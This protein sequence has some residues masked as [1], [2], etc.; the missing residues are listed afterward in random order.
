MLTYGQLA[1]SVHRVA[2][3]L[4]RRGFRKG[5]VFATVC[6][7]ILEFPIVFYAVAALGGTMTMANPLL[8]AEELAR[9]LADAG[10]RFVLTVPERLAAVRDA[11]VASGAEEVF[12]AGEAVDAT[13][14]AALLEQDGHVPVVEIAPGEDV[15]LLPYS[16][17]TTGRQKG[18]MLTHRNLVAKTLSW[19]AVD[20]IAEDEVLAV[21]FPFFTSAVS[22][23]LNI[24][25][26]RRGHPGPP[27]AFRSRART[28]GCCRMRGQPGRSSHR[29]SSWN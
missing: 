4:T 19:H 22:C 10:A 18:V 20:P 24:F 25:L 8:T 11:A 13:P 7:N 21:V 12:V 28:S 27:A 3:G 29:R 17:G 15:A 1:E 23:S 5:D 2:F 16:S 9:Q 26:S 6:P 14:F